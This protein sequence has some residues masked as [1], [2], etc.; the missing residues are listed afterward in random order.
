LEIIKSL[1]SFQFPCRTFDQIKSHLDNIIHIGYDLGLYGLSLGI[2]SLRNHLKS[3]N[4]FTTI[5]SNPNEKELYDK[6]INK[7]DWL[8][9]NPLKELPEDRRIRFSDK[10][11]KVEE[12]IK[13]NSHGQTIVFVER[14]F[15]AA[16][17][18]KI[19][20]E[21]FGKSMEIKYLAGSKAGIAEARVSTTYQVRKYF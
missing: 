5:S 6:I 9:N 12:Y 2:Q 7:L 11:L 13:Q 20:K 21:I 3:T 19:L 1:N 16:F 10:V 4:A 17:L 8:I 14:I 15:T 18:C